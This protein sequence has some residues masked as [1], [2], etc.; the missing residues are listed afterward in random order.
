MK[1]LVGF[2]AVMLALTSVSVP[3]Q[4]K[5]CLKGAI[6]GGVAGHYSGHHAFLGA[7]AGCAIGR[8]EANKRA[9][10]QANQINR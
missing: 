1:F 9:R 8:H 4:A 10:N 7:A 2:A 6:V 5:G 3:A